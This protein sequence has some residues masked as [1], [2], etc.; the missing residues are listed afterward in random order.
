MSVI[1]ASHQ[2]KN[3]SY[4]STLAVC[5]VVGALTSSLLTAN[6]AVCEK[7]TFSPNATSPA[8][9]QRLGRLMPGTA[10]HH[11]VKAPLAPRDNLGGLA[12]YLADKFDNLSCTNRVAKMEVDD[13]PMPAFRP[14]FKAKQTA[15]AKVS[16]QKSV[17]IPA[18]N[19][20][21]KKNVNARQ[22]DKQLT[23][24][25]V[26]MDSKNAAGKANADARKQNNLQRL[27]GNS[28]VEASAKTK[29]SATNTKS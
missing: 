9:A 24:A 29:H 10:R 28:D 2:E 20:A 18:S 6:A 23:E 1:A 3:G 12:R 27:F 14:T 25:A 17:R 21:S 26:H 13:V 4:K 16:A 22:A 15:N 19:S 7:N 5:T 8:G 11:G